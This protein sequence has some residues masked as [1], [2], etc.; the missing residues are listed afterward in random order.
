MKHDETEVVVML[1]NCL[2]RSLEKSIMNHSWI[3]VLF[4][5]A[6][7]Y[8]AARNGV[9]FGVLMIMEKNMCRTACAQI[10]AM[11]LRVAR[12]CL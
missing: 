3:L 7:I 10:T 5:V 6:G 11:N 9:E 8:L 1:S 2:R 12:I 4:S